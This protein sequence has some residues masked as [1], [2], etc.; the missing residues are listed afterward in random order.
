MHLF[1]LSLRALTPPTACTHT[2]PPKGMLYLLVAV[3]AICYWMQ[4]NA[5]KQEYE[6]N[7]REEASLLSANKED[8]E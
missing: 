3:V 1:F 5:A 6:D 2:L 8:A 4:G 7:E